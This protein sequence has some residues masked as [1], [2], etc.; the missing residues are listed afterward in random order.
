MRARVDVTQRATIAEGS[1]TR[2]VAGFSHEH[3]CKGLQTSFV[4]PTLVPAS[5]H[6]L[7]GSQ[8]RPESWTA[9][10]KASIAVRAPATA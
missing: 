10:G 7:T 1:S 5:M 6:Q 8:T 9:T 3:A 4:L 2:R